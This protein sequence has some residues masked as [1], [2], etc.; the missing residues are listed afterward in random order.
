MGLY[1]GYLYLWTLIVK[2]F[3]GGFAVGLEKLAVSIAFRASG[4]EVFEFHRGLGFW[5]EWGPGCRRALGFRVY[6]V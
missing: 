5:G 1:L 2:P 4:F 6:R 3:F